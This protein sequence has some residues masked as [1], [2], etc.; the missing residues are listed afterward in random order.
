MQSSAENTSAPGATTRTTDPKPRTRRGPADLSAWVAATRDPSELILGV[1][2]YAY[3]DLFDPTK[4]AEL[5]AFFFAEVEKA[6]P[7]T[8][9]RFD[10]YRVCKGEG[11]HGEDVSSAL[12]ALAPHVSSFVARLFGVESE[13]AALEAGANE[14]SVLWV[15][16]RE[17]AKK[18]LFKTSAGKNWQG[19]LIEAAHAA[20]RALAALGAEPVLLE[21]GSDDEELAVARAVVSLHEV[22]DVARKAAKAG[23]AT[24]TADLHA[25]A[26]SVRAALQADPVLARLRDGVL[27]TASDVATEGEDGALIALAM[28]AVEAWLAARRVTEHDRAGRWFSLKA[29]EV[30]DHN[31]L[32]EVSRPDPDLPELFVGP[33]GERRARDGFALTDRRASAR[34]IESEADYCLLCHER[35]K[36]S[37]S[38]GLR[39]N[40]TGAIKTNPLGVSLDG[41]PLGEKISEMHAARRTGDA[42][43]GLAL[44]CV[45]NPMVPGTG[46]RI[47]ND[48]MRGCVY[49]KQDPVDTPQVETS[50][51]TDVLALPW[52]LEIY[53]FLT[54]WNPLNVA[55]PHALAYNGKN[56]LIVGLGPAGYTLAHHLTA[57]GF[58]CAAVDGLKLEPLPVELTGDETHAP[59]PVKHFSELYVELD[60]RVAL[61]FGGVSEYG[62]TVRWDK[63]FLTVLYVTLARQRLFKSYGGVRFGGTITLDEAWKLGFDH[64]AIAAGAGRPTIIP[65]KNNLARGI[66]KA[67]DFLMSLQLTGAYKRSALANLQVRLPAIVIGGGLTAI[68]T[69]TEL[70]A[71]Y[72][73]QAEKTTERVDTLIRERGEADVMAMFDAEEREFLDEQRAHGRLIAAERDQARLEGRAPNFHS[74]IDAWGGVS[75][76]YRKRVVDS[77]AYRLNH[78]EVI[79]SLEEGVRFIENLAPLE[80]K[81]DDRDSV[82]AMSFER[83]KLIDG[84]WKASGEIIDLPARTICIAAGTSPNVMYEKENPGTFAMDKWKQFFLAHRATVDDAGQLTIEPVSN[85]REGFFTSYNDGKHAVSFYGDNHPHY[86]GSVVKAMASAKDAHPSVVALFRHDLAKLS[87]EPQEARD[88]R[89]RQLFARLDDE[90]CATVHEVRRLTQTIVEVVIR[91][92]AATRKF[93]PGQFYR[94]QNFEVA[95][96]IIDGTRLSMEGLALTGASVDKEKGL[97]TLIALEMGT[98]SR[99]LTTL[100]PGEPV[101]LMGPTG[102]PTEIP[103]N[104]TVLLA[105]G[106]LGNAV[107]FS[108]ARALRSRGDRVIYFAGYK[109]GEDLFKQED[110]EAA[111]DQVIWC[112]D[113]G[114]EIAPRR[115]ADRHFRGNIVQ[116]MTAYAEGKLGGELFKLAGVARII[117]IGSDRMMNAVREARHGV[118]AR[119][120]DPKHLGLG[121]I[122]SPMQC[123]MKEVCAQ[124]LQKHVDPSTGK[125]TIVFSCFNQDQ[126]LDHVDFKNLGARLRANTAQEKLA[127]AWLDRILAK[128]PE[129][130]RV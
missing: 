31:H 89:R 18:R 109:R 28:D 93:E 94:L 112:T 84:K 44:V 45:D 106:G 20:R 56:V 46:H 42:V 113:V 63:N 8:F 30:L 10:A 123:M 58:A 5:M 107:L 66:R 110:I 114:A 29:P 88:A 103:D 73:V 35:D 101:V 49:Q 96:P 86:A 40:K 59:R 76:V 95:S 61:G 9:A 24:W 25:R 52:G 125:E 102:A 32:V 81:L 99:L 92:P 85:P 111:T 26:A 70:I 100:K 7:A 36:D 41:C 118:L 127:N 55:R 65:L 3:A 67:S 120:L 91:A 19:S 48:C 104:E 53:G 23:G 57:E 14:R 37:C 97:L 34:Q 2:G 39:D 21:S 47:C 119:H 1:T 17:F 38:K 79:Q 130:R 74:L 69:A 122:N 12:L 33:E 129:L 124:C 54:R 115:D 77:P 11:M 6:D 83:Q 64:A 90:L 60:E 117:A 13:L 68:D 16:K 87:D 15:F 98:S 75:L 78:E 22:D 27:A 4:L 51:L 108:I 82:R 71:Y 43:A 116:A 121:S 80:A 50:V 126:A 72:V 62:I 105:G 128:R